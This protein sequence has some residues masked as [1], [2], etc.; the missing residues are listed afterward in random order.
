MTFASNVARNNKARKINTEGSNQLINTIR[1]ES[2][3][4]HFK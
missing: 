3:K 2:E 4:I 1:K